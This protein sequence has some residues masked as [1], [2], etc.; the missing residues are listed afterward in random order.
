MVATFLSPAW[1]DQVN[2]AARA[3]GG[4]RAATAGARVTVQQVVTGGPD[5]DVRYWL[6]LDDGAVRVVAGTAPSPDATVTQSWDT[7]AAVRAGRLRI[8]EALAAGHIRLAG[9]L[10]TLARHQGALRSVAAAV[11]DAA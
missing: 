6:E 3:D 7:A 9:D 2:E 4:L 1:F 5:G 10:G 8:E 11:G